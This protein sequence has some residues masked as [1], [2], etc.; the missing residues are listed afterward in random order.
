MPETGEILKRTGAKPGRCSTHPTE[1]A[2]ASCDVCERALC[3]ACAIPVRGRVV[4]P[5]C[6]ATLVEDPPEQP[7]AVPTPRPRG[8]WFALAGF[9]LVLVASIFPWARYGETTGFGQAWTLHWSLLSVLPAAAGVAAVILVRRR[10]LD[11]TVAT[12]VYAVLATL[13]VFGAA[14]HAIR[15]PPITDTAGT[16]PWRFAVFGAALVLIGAARKAIDA[17]PR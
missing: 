5:E 4:G 6:L 12:A 14:L 1:P 13:V 10:R 16:W 9:I 8:D 17:A 11:A 15:P 2:L 7:P 3:V